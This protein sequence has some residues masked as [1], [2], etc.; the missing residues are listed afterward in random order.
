MN[1]ISTKNSQKFTFVAAM[2]SLRLDRFLISNDINLTRSYLY[3]LAKK[4]LISVNG[5]PSKVGKKIKTGDVITVEIPSQE[6]VSAIIPEDIPFSVIYED[7]DILLIDKPPGYAVHPGPGHSHQT[8]V[9]GLVKKLP[10]IQDFGLNFRPGLIHRLDKDTSGLM[11]VAKT[12]HSF[13]NIGQQ[14]I[15][16]TIVKRYIGLVSGEFRYQ[17][18]FI[19]YPIARH[20]KDRKKMAVISGGKE[21]ITEIIETQTIGKYTLIEMELKTGRTHQLRVHLSHIGYPL[22]GDKTYGNTSKQ[23]G[24]QFL[25]A[26]YLSFS[27]PKSMKKVE[28]FSSLPNDLQM[29]LS[30]IS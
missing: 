15:D 4:E 24:R 16:K 5:I 18:S 21:S 26:S 9:N 12:K 8:I 29:F 10:N 2:N 7:Q 3:T 6:T 14:W 23:L 13:A 11:V 22:I 25:H 20:P 17:K 27:H 28:Y 1:P 19:N 30:G